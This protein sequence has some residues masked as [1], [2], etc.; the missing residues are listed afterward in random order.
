[1]Q[2]KNAQVNVESMARMSRGGGPALRKS[3]SVVMARLERKGAHL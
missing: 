1:M 2:S 3:A